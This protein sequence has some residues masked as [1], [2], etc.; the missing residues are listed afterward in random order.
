MSGLEGRKPIPDPHGDYGRLTAEGIELMVSQA[1]AKYRR[2]PLQSPDALRL[3]IEYLD[4]CERGCRVRRRHRRREYPGV[5]GVPQDRAHARVYCGKASDRRNRL[6]Q[7]SNADID[8][9]WI[10]VEV[11]ADAS[12]RPPDDADGVGLVRKQERAVSAHQ[13]DQL[14]YWSK[15]ALHRIHGVNDYEPS[16]NIRRPAEKTLEVSKVVVRETFHGRP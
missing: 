8:G 15:M 10:E 11:L 13:I 2:I 12:S 4:A 3:P 14:R 9:A 7:G 1:S 16:W 5:R 6:A